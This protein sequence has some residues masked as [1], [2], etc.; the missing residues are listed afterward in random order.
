[1]IY[2]VDVIMLDVQLSCRQWLLDF[3]TLA[4]IDGLHI[5]PGDLDVEEVIGSRV[6][7]VP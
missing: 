1:M 7:P 5:V 2:E 6:W 4:S 3:K